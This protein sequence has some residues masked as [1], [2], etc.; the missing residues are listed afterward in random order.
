MFPCVVVEDG[1]V[2]G[3]VFLDWRKGCQG[4]FSGFRYSNWTEP[5]VRVRTCLVTPVS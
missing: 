1:R 3:Y 2:V 5:S 4:L